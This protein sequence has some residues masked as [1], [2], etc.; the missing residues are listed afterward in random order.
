MAKRREERS[1]WGRARAAS[2]AA[3]PLG[4]YSV[5]FLFSAK[6]SVFHS[7]SPGLFLTIHWNNP[8]RQP[9]PTPCGLE[10]EKQSH[11]RDKKVLN[12]YLFPRKG[13]LLESKSVSYI[14]L[15]E[16][17]CQRALILGWDLGPQNLGHGI[18]LRLRFN[19]QQQPRSTT[20]HSP[21]QAKL[22]RHKNKSRQNN[23]GT[24]LT[25]THS[26]GEKFKEYYLRYRAHGRPNCRAQPKQPSP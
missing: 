9:E 24:L 26:T 4:R 18:C 11:E 14:L 17:R 5:L 19:K 22:T 16:G 21:V 3:K 23:T 2:S 1:E 20:H 12:S 6:C 7:L 13:A 25:A 15:G 8:K 10:R